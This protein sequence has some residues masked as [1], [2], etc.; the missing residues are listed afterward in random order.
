MDSLELATKPLVATR[1]TV[2]LLS[3]VCNQDYSV[4]HFVTINRKRK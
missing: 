4:Y 3:R 1:L 2:G